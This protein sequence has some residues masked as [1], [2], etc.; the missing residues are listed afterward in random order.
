MVGVPVD[1]VVVGGSVDVEFEETVTVSGGGG[2]M[3]L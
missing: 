2:V 1:D 3:V